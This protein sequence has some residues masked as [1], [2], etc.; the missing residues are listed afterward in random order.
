MTPTVTPVPGADSAAQALRKAE[1]IEALNRQA[2]ILEKRRELRKLQ[3]ADGLA[4][5]G[6]EQKVLESMWDGL[7]NQEIAHRAGNSIKTIEAHRAR[8]FTKLGASNGIQAVR[9]ALRRGY[10]KVDPPEAP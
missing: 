3:G 5:T 2:A 8:I 1:E 6:R 4:L 7:T 9:I 10:L